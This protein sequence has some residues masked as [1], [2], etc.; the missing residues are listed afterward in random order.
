MS[1]YTMTLDNIINFMSLEEVEKLCNR[2]KYNLYKI[3]G[4]DHNFKR[5]NTK[6]ELNHKIIDFLKLND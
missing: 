3:I 2:F 5:N 6:E 4:A 1:K